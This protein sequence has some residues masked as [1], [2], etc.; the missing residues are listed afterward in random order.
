[1]YS[2]RQFGIDKN[3]GL[4]KT[5]MSNDWMHGIFVNPIHDQKIKMIATLIVGSQLVISGIALMYFQNSNVSTL[6]I[7]KDMSLPN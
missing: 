2:A 1:M 5:L 6:I 7:S 4:G 3:D